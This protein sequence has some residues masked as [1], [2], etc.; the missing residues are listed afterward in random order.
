MRQRHVDDGGIRD[1]H[2][3]RQR[4]R[5]RH[6]PGLLAAASFGSDSFHRNLRHHG[7]SQRQRFIRVRAF[8][9]NDF[10]GTRWTIFT[11]LPV[12]FSAGKVEKREPEPI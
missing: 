5:Y 3:Y 2:E 12:A 6:Q 1:L 4:H 7:E 10:T 8:V 9:D 11:K